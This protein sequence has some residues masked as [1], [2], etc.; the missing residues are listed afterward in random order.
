MMSGIHGNTGNGIAVIAIHPLIAVPVNFKS[1]PVGDIDNVVR[2]AADITIREDGGVAAVSA[3]GIAVAVTGDPLIAWVNSS[4]CFRSDS[5]L[6]V[7][8]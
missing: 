7:F 4:K 5:I 2:A 8:G 1:G 3:R 6:G